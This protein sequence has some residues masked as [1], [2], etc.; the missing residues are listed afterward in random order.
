[1]Q[2]SP[3]SVHA[4]FIFCLFFTAS[5]DDDQSQP[6]NSPDQTSLNADDQQSYGDEQNRLLPQI[7]MGPGVTQPGSS[8]LKGICYALIP[9]APECVLLVLFLVNYIMTYLGETFCHTVPNFKYY[10][11]GVLG[12]QGSPIGLF[13]NVLS[14]SSCVYHF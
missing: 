3:H 2:S 8:P 6:S 14:K 10:S 4:V 13:S 9:S 11:L 12:L 7:N 1:M 5:L